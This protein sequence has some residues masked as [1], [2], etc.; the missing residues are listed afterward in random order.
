MEN[1][2]SVSEME[3]LRSDYLNGRDLD[4][5]RCGQLL[6]S[7]VEEGELLQGQCPRG[8]TFKFL[9]VDCLCKEVSGKIILSR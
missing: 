9:V 7:C 2:F 1:Q 5:P 6:M 4:C 3:N 8:P